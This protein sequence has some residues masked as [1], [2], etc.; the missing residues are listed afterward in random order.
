MTD[1]FNSVFTRLKKPSI[2]LTVVSQIGALLI[3]CGVRIDENLLMTA[4]AMICSILCT[5]GI[6]NSTAPA[7]ETMLVCSES[8]EPKAH[9]MIA[10]QMVCK[11]CGAVY[12]APEDEETDEKG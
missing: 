3:L 12:V 1:F 8:G 10:G 2:I 7:D 9:V 11:N 5:L 6:L 4:T